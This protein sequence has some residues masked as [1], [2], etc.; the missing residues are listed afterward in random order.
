[1][2]QRRSAERRRMAR[3][4]E[5]AARAGNVGA[6]DACPRRG[7]SQLEGLTLTRRR[8]S[9]SARRVY[10]LLLDYDS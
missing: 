1:M 4:D 2:V 3:H 5:L 10:G 8:D 9:V 6:A 7:S